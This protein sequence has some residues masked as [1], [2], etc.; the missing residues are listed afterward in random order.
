MIKV[1]E[2]W[3]Q[4]SGLFKCPYCNKE[5]SKNGISTHIWRN[6][7]TNGK[8]F[9]PFKIKVWNKGL[10]KETDERVKK[11]GI[12]FSNNIKNGKIDRNKFKN[13]FNGRA[14]TAEKEKIR[15]KKIKEKSYNLG[16]YR[17][18]SGIGK[19]GYYKGYWCDSSWELAFVIYCLE[20][21]IKFERNREG[22]DYIYENKNHKFY[23][24]F[25]LDDGTYIEIKGRRSYKDLDEKSKIKINSFNKKIK[26]LFLNEM[27]I[28][29]KYVK[30]K[31]GDNFINLYQ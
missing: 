29:L 8:K 1:L 28:Y 7:T 13:K 10:T 16:G 2:K 4:K 27:K 31:Y 9:K 21:D 14:S 23:P 5:Y 30:N 3:K 6:H 17:K 26:I 19:K 12:T 24:D 18:G 22:F 20:H 15:I 25:I 11:Q